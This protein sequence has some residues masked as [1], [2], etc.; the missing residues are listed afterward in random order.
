ME[1]KSKKKKGYGEYKNTVQLDIP[2]QLLDAGV[3]ST[4]SK[5]GTFVRSGSRG[6]DT[7]E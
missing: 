7:S 4:E 3:T 6:G 5:V 1:I 2:L